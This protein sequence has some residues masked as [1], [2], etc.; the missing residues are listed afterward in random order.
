MILFNYRFTVQHKIILL[1]NKKLKQR[2]RNH[3]ILALPSWWP[4]NADATEMV[5]SFASTT[6]KNQSIP[7]QITSDFVQKKQKNNN[8]V[9]SS[10]NQASL[11]SI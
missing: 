2:M 5:P 9:T 7:T 3:W 4:G 11:Q 10:H 8:S 1:M 6:T